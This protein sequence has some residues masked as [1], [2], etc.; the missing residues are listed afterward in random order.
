MMTE[1]ELLSLI[2]EKSPE[3]LSVDECEALRAGFS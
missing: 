2:H 1:E 3:E